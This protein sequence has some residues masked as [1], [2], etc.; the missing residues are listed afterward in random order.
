M[1]LTTI[2]LDIKNRMIRIGFGLNDGNWFVR[3]DMWYVG[4]RLTSKNRK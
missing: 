3:V 1:K 4:F 2:P